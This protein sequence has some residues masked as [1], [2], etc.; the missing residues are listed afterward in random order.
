MSLVLAESI[1]K[2]WNISLIFELELGG[3]S[4]EA[5]FSHPVREFMFLIH[6]RLEFNEYCVESMEHVDLYFGLS[7]FLL[8]VAPGLILT[9]FFGDW[10][11]FLVDCVHCF[12]FF[13]G[14]KGH[15]RKVSIAWDRVRWFLSWFIV[16]LIRAR[17]MVNPSRKYSN[18]QLGD[19]MYF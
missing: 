6:G 9:S 16:G 7:L 1:P 15:L 11:I 13:P 4:K 10:N 8:K 18:H 2:I 14:M 19:P 17:F 5:V 12:G 3:Y